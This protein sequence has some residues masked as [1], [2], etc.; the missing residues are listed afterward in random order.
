MLC[1][2]I[3]SF[4]AQL[5]VDAAARMALS[6]PVH[7]DPTQAWRVGVMRPLRAIASEDRPTET[8]ILVVDSL[9]ELLAGR[10]HDDNVLAL[11]RDTF[12]Q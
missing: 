9:D 5:G 8:K 4:R 12:C 11:L 2:S 3:P 7:V 1:R 10:E 6:E